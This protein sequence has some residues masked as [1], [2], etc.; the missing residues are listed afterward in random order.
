[1]NEEQ[2]S[3]LMFKSALVGIVDLVGAQVLEICGL[4]GFYAAKNGS[5]IPT[6]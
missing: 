6:A 3:F 5:S 2:L 4:L 1:M